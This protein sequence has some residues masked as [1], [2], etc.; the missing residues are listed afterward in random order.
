MVAQIHLVGLNVAV[1]KAKGR[2]A[3]NSINELSFYKPIF[4]GDELSCYA[5]VIRIG[6]TTLTLNIEV[7]VPHQL[8]TEDVKVT[9]DV[10][11]FIAIN[12]KNEPRPLSKD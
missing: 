6:R 2:V 3:A 12:H 1:Y 4:V 7:W 5:E 11:T 8:Q 10:F 9:E